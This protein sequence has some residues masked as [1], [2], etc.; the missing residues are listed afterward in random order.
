MGHPALV[1]DVVSYS[2]HSGWG[3]EG[4]NQ[5]IETILI[6]LCAPQQHSFKDMAY[7]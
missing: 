6:G 4:C 1:A 3:G 5:V 7:Q 2:M